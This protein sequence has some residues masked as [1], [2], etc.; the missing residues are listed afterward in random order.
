M[1]SQSTEQLVI[2]GYFIFFKR[3]GRKAETC[4]FQELCCICWAGGYPTRLVIWKQS[5]RLSLLICFPLFP[6]SFKGASLK[7]NYFLVFLQ[8]LFLT[9]PVEMLTAITLPIPVTT[10]SPSVPHPLTSTTGTGW[11]LQR[12]EERAQVVEGGQGREEGTSRHWSRNLVSI[13]SLIPLNSPVS[14]YSNG[15]F[16]SLLN[17]APQLESETAAMWV[18]VSLSLQFVLFPLHFLGRSFLISHEVLK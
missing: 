18:K 16:K 5:K 2:C 17:R 11:P 9:A 3:A 8:K 7:L 13:I 4:C 15:E 12:W 6:P 10:H 1:P 14:V